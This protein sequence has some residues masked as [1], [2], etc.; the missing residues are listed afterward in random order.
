MPFHPRPQTML[1]AALVSAACTDAQPFVPAGG[2][3]PLGTWGGDN[4][5]LIVTDSV[6]HAHIGCTFGDLPPGIAIDDEGRFTADGSWVLRAFPIVVGPSLPAQL[7]GRLVGR[8]ITFAVAVND[9]VEKKVVSLGPV[10]VE[11][12][13]EPQLGPCPI[14]RV[15]RP[16]PTVKKQDRR[17][18]RSAGPGGPR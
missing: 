17:G 6:T 9:T 4:A 2:T 5:G 13:R 11:L 18:G 10:T 3:L 7:S 16:T 8:R 15:P 14:C 1:L 12:G